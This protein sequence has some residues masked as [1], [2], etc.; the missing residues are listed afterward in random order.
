[1]YCRKCKAKLDL[2]KTNLICDKC[3]YDNLLNAE[4]L[5][6]V[7]DAMAKTSPNYEPEYTC[8]K[9]G[10][11]NIQIETNATIQSTPYSGINGLMGICCLGLPGLLCGLTGGQKITPREEKVCRDCGTR[12]I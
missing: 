10:S 12:F 1:M 5:P 3:G 9:C 7:T 4:N 8:P 2:N 6:L 11:H